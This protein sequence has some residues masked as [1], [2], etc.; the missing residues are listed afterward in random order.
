VLFR[1]AFNLHYLLHILVAWL[2]MRALCIER[3]TS[4][5]AANFAATV[6]VLSGVVI[7]ATALYN[8]IVNIVMVPL[9]LLAIERRSAQLLGAAIGLMALAA[10]PVTMLGTLLILAIAAFRRVSWKTLIVGACLAVLIA[11]PVLIAFSEIAGDAERTAG[12]RPEIVLATALSPLRIAEIFVWPFSGFLN[13]G[14]GDRMRMFS[15]IFVGLIALPALV[16]RSRYV[17]MVLLMLFLAAENP[18]VTEAVIRFDWLRIGRYPEKFVI[19]LTAALVVLIGEYFHRTRFRRAWMVITLVPLIWVAYRALPIDW[20]SYYRLPPV[21]PGRIYQRPDPGSG[22]EPARVEYRRRALQIDPL[23]GMPGGV[24]YVMLPS[25]DA[26]GS[27]LTQVVTS[28]FHAVPAA[29]KLRY[30]QIRGVRIPYSV[31]LAMIVPRTIPAASLRDAVRL[32]ESPSFGPQT[33]AVAPVA[34][35]SAP[36][37]ITR[38]VEDGQTIFID[39]ESRGEALV[40]VN[41]TFYKAWQATMNGRELPTMSLNIDRLGVIVPGSG[42][43]TLRFGRHRAAVAMAAIVS[44]LLVIAAFAIEIRQRRTGQVERTGDHD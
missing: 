35:T 16:R 22:H 25:P 9:A 27:R 20:F 7:S 15:T 23:S 21:T 2:V 34:F 8:H 6:Y 28:R 36:A 13:D 5:A 26:M 3:K 37:R 40:L 44:L 17:V 39:V 12:L 11:S 1:S 19:P 31:P 14:G 38:A 43:I 32:V 33:A 42:R 10:E 30:L 4:L 18:I 24:G 41:Q 29:L